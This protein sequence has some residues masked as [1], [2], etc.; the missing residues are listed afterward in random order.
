MPFDPTLPADHSPLSSAEMRN[1]LN[2][3]RDELDD[4]CDSVADSRPD[5]ARVG[6]LITEQAAGIVGP[7]VS[8]LTLTVSDPPT[9]AEVQAIVDA[10]NLLL[11]ALRRE[12]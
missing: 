3:L 7:A 11:G 6:E 2:G 9:Q 8:P 12:F 1:Q 4:R 10:Y 5:E